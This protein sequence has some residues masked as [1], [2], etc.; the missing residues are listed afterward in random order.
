MAKEQKEIIL[1]DMNLVDKIINIAEVK[2]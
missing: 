2:E 1:D